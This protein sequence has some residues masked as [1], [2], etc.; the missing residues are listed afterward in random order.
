MSDNYAAYRARTRFANLDGLRFICI[1]M[2]L[3]HHAQPVSGDLSPALS[4]GF[5]GVD[6][7][8]CSADI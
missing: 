4:R 1:A 5:L 7:S 2:V 8:L 3:W 6:S